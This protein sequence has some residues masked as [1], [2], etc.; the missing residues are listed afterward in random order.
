MWEN[1]CKQSDEWRINLQNI[2]TADGTQLKK[3][4]TQ[5]KK[6]G[7]KLKQTCLQRWET[8]DKRHIKRCSALL[9]IQ[10]SCPVVSASL[11]YHG[12][13]H[14]RLPCPSQF[15]ELAQTHVHRVGDA[16]Q[17]SH[18]MLSPSPPAFDPSQQQ[19]LFQWVSSSHQVAKV[20][21]SPQQCKGRIFLTHLLELGKKKIFLMGLKSFL[22]QRK[23]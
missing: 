5:S 16:I 15:L 22:T 9:I 11:W 14:A 3:K 4:K 23:P 18:P 21:H 8:D 12:L 6:M 1:I 20:L 13:Q 19:G 2:Q 17:P 10:F 7:G